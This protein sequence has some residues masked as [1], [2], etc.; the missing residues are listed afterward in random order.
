MLTNVYYYNIYRPYIVS[1]RE[2]NRFTPKQGRIADRK[3]SA[4]PLRQVFVLNKALKDEIINY[5]HAVSYG[6]TNLKSSARATADDMENFNRN[7]HKEGFDTAREWLS[8]DLE[9]FAGR[10]N[11]A[12][13][14]M[15]NQ[16]HSSS[17]RIFSYELAD[18][19]RYNKERLALLGLNLGEEGRVGFDK[20]FL[21]SLSHE[22]INI[23]IGENIQIFSGLQK[24]AVTFLDAPLAEH[25]RFK[26]LGYHYNYKLG[27]M[28]MDGFDVI[29]AGLLIDKAV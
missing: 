12:A 7:V 15:Q 14:F 28:E 1:N 16:S 24:H 8:E 29:E 21:K 9:E 4:E 23:A 11:E 5:A 10:A 6:V 3:T 19:L 2:P 17:V 25:M 20:P 13:E 22:K 26:G 18:N 27:K